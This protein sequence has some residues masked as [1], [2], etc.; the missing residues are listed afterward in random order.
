MRAAFH[1]LSSAAAFMSMMEPTCNGEDWL[2]ATDGRDMGRP[3]GTKPED[4]V[5][6]VRRQYEATA[7]LKAR[8]DDHIGAEIATA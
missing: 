1:N 2:K 7:R 8:D 3:R 5:V 4:K 6:L